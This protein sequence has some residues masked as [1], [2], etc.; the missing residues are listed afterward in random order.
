[1]ARMFAQVRLAIWSDDDFRAVPPNE[2]HLYFVLMTSPSLSHCGVADWRP[3]RIASLAGGW[4]PEQVIA[5][6]SGLMDKLYVLVDQSTEEVLVRSFIRHDEIMKQPKMAAAM[7]SAHAA[8]ASAA[9]RGVVVHELNRL[10]VDEP[11]L[12][13]WTG[14]G[15]EELLA[16]GSVDP[17]TYPL[18][19]GSVLGSTKGSTKGSSWGKSTPPFKGSGKGSVNGSPTP[20]PTPTPSN[21]HL[22]DSLRS[23]GASAPPKRSKPRK[24]L[25]DDW[26]PTETHHAYAAEHG[27]DIGHE[28]GQ[29]RAHAEANDRQQADWDATFRTWMGNNVKWDRPRSAPAA[30]PSALDGFQLPAAPKSVMDDP[31]SAAYVRWARQ[32]RDEWLAGRSA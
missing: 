9:L 19:K 7:S 6:A 30:E 3:P 18:G 15:V 21:Q 5:A 28:V 14:K 16:K 31:D 20:A 12:K 13:G 27:I 29:F 2:Q 8:A 32:Q 4:T 10:R 22:S 1:M 24:R 17:S 26:S 23:S 11:D 25:P